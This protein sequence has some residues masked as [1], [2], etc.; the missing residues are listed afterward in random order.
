[1]R[2]ITNAEFRAHSDPLFTQL[3]IL[4]YLLLI[5]RSTTTIQVLLRIIVLMLVEPI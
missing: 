3:G 1:M 2:I 4:A 5:M